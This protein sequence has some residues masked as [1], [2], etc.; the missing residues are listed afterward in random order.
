MVLA[1]DIVSETGTVLVRAGERLSRTLAQRVRE[2]ADTV[3]VE[4]PIRVI[5]HGYR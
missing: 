4:E 2:F 1:D 3:G 5:V